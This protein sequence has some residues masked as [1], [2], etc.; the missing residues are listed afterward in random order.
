[1]WTARRSH[2]KSTMDSRH[3]IKSARLHHGAARQHMEL[4]KDL[5][6]TVVPKRTV[7]RAAGIAIHSD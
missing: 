5:Y 4:Q 7:E 6:S 3:T 1:M 2:I